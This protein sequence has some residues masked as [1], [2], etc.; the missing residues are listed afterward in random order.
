MSF[1]K[2]IR[3]LPFFSTDFLYPREAVT[4]PYRCFSSNC[5]FCF[6]FCSEKI[7]AFVGNS[8]FYTFREI[9]LFLFQ[10]HPLLAVI[11]YHHSLIYRLLNVSQ[12]HWPGSSPRSRSCPPQSS[13]PFSTVTSSLI[14]EF[15][16]AISSPPSPD[17]VP[18]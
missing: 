14:P 18:H 2:F 17:V 9:Y 11:F 4:F 12:L 6:C 16:G 8:N 13:C 10:F 5:T 7:L 3:F 1:V 15:L